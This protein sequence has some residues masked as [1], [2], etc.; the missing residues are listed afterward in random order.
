L[1][2]FVDDVVLMVRVHNT[3]LLEEWANFTLDLMGDWLAHHGMRVAP[4]K[5]EAV[6]LTRKWAYR[7]PVFIMNGQ[8]IPVKPVFRYLGLDTRL[9]FLSQAT[10][11]A[12]AARKIIAALCRLMSNIHRPLTGKRLLLLSMATS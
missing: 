8:R 1:I 12:D 7:E 3:S 5:S 9:K 4:A 6:I 11:A 2:G 10:M